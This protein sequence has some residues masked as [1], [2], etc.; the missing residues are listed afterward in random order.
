MT[1]GTS[2]GNEH[3]IYSPEGEFSS[4]RFEQWLISADITEWPRLD[5]GAL[6]LDGDAFRMMYGAHPTIEGLHALRDGLGVIVR[7]RIPIG[8]DGR[9]RPSLFP[10]GT[11]TGR[12]A[13]SKSLYSAHA[14]M[15]SF[16]RFPTE[17]IGLYPPAN[18]RSRIAAA[19]SGDAIGQ[20][21]LAGTRITRS[22]SS[23]V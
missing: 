15:R 17:K 20:E 8:R 4:W 7:A 3:P 21:L 5:S 18:A 22:Q 11:A 10:F 16:M 23:A 19:H 2:R 13:Q 6:H 14:S 9:N 12:N 1:R